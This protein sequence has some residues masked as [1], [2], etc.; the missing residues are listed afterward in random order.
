MSKPYA[1]VRGG[2]EV[3]AVGESLDDAL[4]SACAAFYSGC[5]PP[6]LR[7][8]E[9]ITGSLPDIAAVP[10]SDR[11]LSSYSDVVGVGPTLVIDGVLGL[12]GEDQLSLF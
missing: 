11:L 4:A 1:I 9:Q 3:I 10:C 12:E 8:F 2:L 6:Q 5:L 7:I